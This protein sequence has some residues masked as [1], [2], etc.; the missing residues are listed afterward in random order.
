MSIDTFPFKLS[1]PRVMEKCVYEFTIGTDKIKLK[2]IVVA[3]PDKK[4]VDIS[5]RIID[6][7]TA[8]FDVMLSVIDRKGVRQ[9]QHHPWPRRCHIEPGKDALIANNNY[10]FYIKRCVS[11]KEERN[12]N[13]V[14]FRL[15]FILDIQDIVTE[16]LENQ[17][18]KG[19]DLPKDSKNDEA[20]ESHKEAQEQQ[21]ESLPKATI[22][23]N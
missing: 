15:N 19:K 11:K 4:T 14:S 7:K 18:K 3:N 20:K 21:K 2:V 16:E 22:S 6:T 5:L 13:V 23:S 8:H 17:T 10:D 1:L 9:K 12:H